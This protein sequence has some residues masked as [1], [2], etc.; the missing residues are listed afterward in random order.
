MNHQ[1]VKVSKTMKSRL[2]RCPM[3]TLAIAVKVNLKVEML[4]I[5]LLIDRNLIG[6]NQN[7]HIVSTRKR[8]LRTVCSSLTIRQKIWEPLCIN[9]RYHFWSLILETTPK[10]VMIS[11]MVENLAKLW[12][13]LFKVLKRR[14]SCKRCQT[15]KSTSRNL[16]ETSIPRRALPLCGSTTM[17][18]LVLLLFWRQKQI[19]GMI[20][21]VIILLFFR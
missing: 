21:R 4:G 2:D 5:K 19:I 6:A 17:V 18:P 8:D 16:N 13:I 14:K 7:L 15:R 1:V 12:T 3:T 9:N 11:S 20:F 10:F